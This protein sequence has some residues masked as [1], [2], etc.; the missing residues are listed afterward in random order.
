LTS[1]TAGAQL[2]QPV[3]RLGRLL[4]AIGLLLFLAGAVCFGMAYLGMKQLRAAGFVPRR[5]GEPFG[6]VHEWEQWQR[7]S[8]VGLTVAAVGLAVAVTAAI[9]WNRQKRSLRGASAEAQF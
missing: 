1:N 3:S 5:P 9:V 7:L 4:D 2:S 6:A 8:W